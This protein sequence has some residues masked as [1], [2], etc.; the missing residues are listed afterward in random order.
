MP[1]SPALA[2]DLAAVLG[3]LYRAAEFVLIDTIK[4]TLATGM[5]LP[6][7]AEQKLA[8]LGDLSSALTGLVDALAAESSGAVREALSTAYDRGQQAAVAELGAVAAGQAAVAAAVLPTAP[9]VDRLAAGVMDRITPMRTAILRQSQDVYRSVIAE[10]SAAPALGIES[11]RQATQRALNRFVDHGVVNFVDNRG[12]AW[13]MAE[14][15][16][17]ALR[18]S[19]GRAAIEAHSDRLEAADVQLVMVSN[20]PLHCPKC[21][22]WAGKILW[23]GRDSAAIKVMLE[24]ATQDGKWVTVDIAGSLSEARA[25]GLLHPNCRCSIAAYLPGVSK[26]PRPIPHPGGATYKDTQ[27]QRELERTVRKWRK[28]EHAALDEPTRKAADAKARAA[29]AKIRKLTEDKGLRRKS[30]RERPMTGH[31]GQG[32]PSGRP[33]PKPT[34]KPTPD[35]PPAA[36]PRPAT[37][38]RTTPPAARTSTPAPAPAR[39][40]PA[41]SR[42]PAA[43]VTPPTPPTS[44]PPQ[45]TAPRAHP[46]EPSAVERAAASDG[47]RH[48]PLKKVPP[49]TPDARQLVRTKAGVEMPYRTVAMGGRA[50]EQALDTMYAH[51]WID[52]VGALTEA[53]RLQ[54]HAYGNVPGGKPVPSV[55]PPSPARPPAL[56]RRYEDPAVMTD[57]ELDAELTYRKGQMKAKNAAVAKAAEARRKAISLYRLRSQLGGDFGAR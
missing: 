2:E 34:P 52:D 25:S 13:G 22:K 27:R 50:R 47:V 55:D 17:M 31:A 57:L 24:H 20:Q 44:A 35:T 16:E 46:A 14:Y 3:D 19:V 4:R 8:A 39:A 38:T 7:W 21:D 18:T 10:A 37:P 36:T 29:Q 53:G 5:S 1:V 56:G 54:A 28:R 49:L 33:A 12:R 15:A 32:G 41:V 23:R 11:R 9:V 6:N 48:P 43:A 26:P 51:G 40:A 45:V 42:P 30:E